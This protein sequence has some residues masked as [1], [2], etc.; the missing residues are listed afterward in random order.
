MPNGMLPTG[1][2]NPWFWLLAVLAVAWLTW[3]P[4]RK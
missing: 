4:E 2:V 3:P 1:E